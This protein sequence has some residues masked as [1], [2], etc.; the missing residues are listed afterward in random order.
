[1]LLLNTSKPSGDLKII[2]GALS[3][4]RNDSRHMSDPIVDLPSDLLTS[5]RVLGRA[6][7]PSSVLKTFILRPYQT[8]LVF[9]H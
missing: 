3:L 9:K 8:F 2:T 7:R 1:M 5:F 6:A 4:H